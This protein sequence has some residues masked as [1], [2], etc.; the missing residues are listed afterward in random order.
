VN[1]TAPYQ[2]LLENSAIGAKD[3]LGSLGIKVLQTN[4]GQVLMVELLLKD[5][6]LSLPNALEHKRLAVVI[7]VGTDSKVDFSWIFVLKRQVR[8]GA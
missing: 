8:I 1:A 3:Q 6:L 4:D 5:S 2:L 7:T